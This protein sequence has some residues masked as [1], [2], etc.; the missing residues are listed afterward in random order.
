MINRLICFLFGH[1]IDKKDV[2][3]TRYWMDFV[4]GIEIAN[5]NYFWCSRCKRYVR[6]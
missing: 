1:D 6:V 4:G 5:K 3:T 2:K